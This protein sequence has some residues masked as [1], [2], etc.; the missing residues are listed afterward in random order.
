MHSTSTAQHSTSTA[1]HST[2]QHSTQQD[3]GRRLSPTSKPAWTDWARDED[4]DEHENTGEPAGYPVNP[5]F[6]S[7]LP[8][9]PQSQ[10]MI[11]NPAHAMYCIVLLWAPVYLRHRDHDDDEP[12]APRTVLTNTSTLLALLTIFKL[13]D[14]RGGL[15]PPLSPLA[16]VMQLGHGPAAV[17]CGAE[18]R[19]CATANPRIIQNRFHRGTDGRMMANSQ[20]PKMCAYRRPKSSP[21][22]QSK[23][24]PLNTPSMVHLVLN[25]TD[26]DADDD[27][28]SQP[29][30]DQHAFHFGAPYRHVNWDEAGPQIAGY[31]T[32]S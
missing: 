16:V 7:N 27:D 10:P 24:P 25:R 2:A 30:H 23:Y 26:D 11:V 21:K 15:L 31:G 14:Q 18:R 28:F 8:Q 13:L 1:Q 22:S 6:C 32:S 4:E 29:D 17:Q 20:P 12:A 5:D 3:P 19:R 9:P